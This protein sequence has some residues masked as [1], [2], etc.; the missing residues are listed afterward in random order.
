MFAYAMIVDVVERRLHRFSL[1]ANAISV[2]AGLMTFYMVATGMR[3]VRPQT[4]RRRSWID[5]G[6]TLFA[7]LVAAGCFIVGVQAAGR[8]RPEAYPLFVFGIVGALAVS[9]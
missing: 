4:A 9:W 8:G 3:T 7:M 6:A 2:V 1:H 5:R